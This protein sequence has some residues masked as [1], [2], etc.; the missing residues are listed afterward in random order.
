MR[1]WISLLA[2]AVLVGSF[3]LG[4]MARAQDVQPVGLTVRA[5]AFFPTESETRDATEDVWFTAGLEYKLG[6]LGEPDYDNNYRAEYSVSG[7]YYGSGDFT[8]IPVLVNYVGHVD[9]FRYSLGIGVTFADTPD[10][11]NETVFGY[12]FAVGYE[13]ATGST[14]FFIEGGY[15]GASGSGIG[16]K[17]NGFFAGVGFRF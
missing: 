5:G 3:A 16:S 17:L 11:D 14:P 6:N 1:N 10:D 2:V 4:T 15:M 8:A 13:F 7:D 12:R 9:T